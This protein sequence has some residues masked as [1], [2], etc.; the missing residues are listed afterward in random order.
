MNTLAQTLC[1]YVDA[2]FSGLWVE[3]FEPD[4]AVKE[5]DALCRAENW[6]YA[7]WDIEQG[8]QHDGGYQKM[9]PLTVI[10][11]LG[12]LADGKKPILLV[13]RNFHRFLGSIDIVQ[14]VERQIAQGKIRR[15]FVVVLA[16]VVQIPAELEKL[17]VVVE[18]P[19][20]DKEQLRQIAK[21]LSLNS[22]LLK[23]LE[24]R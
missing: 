20:P 23:E 6:K 5:I 10:Q 18:H 7:V 8:L 13:L 11:T 12:S 16:P 15:A 9:D 4:E 14:A 22:N 24:L 17:F 1:S 21:R 19:L 2:A 3:T